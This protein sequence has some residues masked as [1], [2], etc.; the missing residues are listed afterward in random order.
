MAG[1]VRARRWARRGAGTGWLVLVCA[2]ACRPAPSEGPNVNADAVQVEIQASFDGLVAAVLAR[3]TDRYLSYFDRT[4]FV[5]L[6]ADG[7]T[8]HTFEDFARTYRQQA[9]AVASYRSLSFDPVRISVIDD[10]TAILVNEFDAEVELVSGDVVVATGGGT[11]V[12]ARTDDGW[13]L[14]SVSSSGSG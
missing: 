12:W 1:N 5:G 4:R 9:A 11:Q 2:L 6:H 3:D 10:R 13:K 7:T 14:V 8:V